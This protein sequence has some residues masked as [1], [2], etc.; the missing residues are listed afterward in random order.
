MTG[1]LL[2]C[3]RT[4]WRPSPYPLGHSMDNGHSVTIVFSTLTLVVTVMGWYF[5]YQAQQ[6]LALQQRAYEREKEVRQ[7]LTPGRIRQL[8]AIEAW[9]NLALPMMSALRRA[10]DDNEV[11]AQVQTWHSQVAAMF[12]LARQH[13]SMYLAVVEGQIDLWSLE[14]QDLPLDLPQLLTALA[15]FVVL[16][17]RTI[18]RRDNAAA[19]TILQHLVR[20]HGQAQAALERVRRHVA[21][22]GN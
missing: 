4:T 18:R 14:S 15:T 8:D 22:G 10:P 11:K 19:R 12:E 2:G 1:C 13:D 7:N 20:V 5:T 3:P 9:L 21:E 17:A 16:Y 6:A